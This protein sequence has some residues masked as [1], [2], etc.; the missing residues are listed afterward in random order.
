[1]ERVTR[2]ELATSTLGRLHSTTELHPLGSGDS[3]IAFCV[4]PRG[5]RGPGA[6]EGGLHQRR[7]FVG[8]R[9]PFGPDGHPGDDWVVGGGCIGEE[10]HPAAI[11]ENLDAA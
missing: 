2:L 10:R 8:Q 11:S 9:S 3:T 1:M 4:D 7:V 6:A 5:R